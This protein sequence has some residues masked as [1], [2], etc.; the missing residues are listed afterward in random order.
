MGILIDHDKCKGCGL[1]AS[2]CPGN[3]ISRSEDG[4]VFMEY[5]KDCWGCCA[6]IKECNYS[7]ISLYLGADICGNGSRMTVTQTGDLL[8][9][10]IIKPDKTTEKIIIDRKKPNEY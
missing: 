6:C 3:L 7:A 2:I 5:P 10:N 8:A 4:T 1:C 9:W